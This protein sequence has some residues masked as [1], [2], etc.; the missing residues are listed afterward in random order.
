MEKVRIAC[1]CKLEKER[2]IW[3]SLVIPVIIVLSVL[4]IV[5]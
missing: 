1:Q 5:D 3:P 4:L 2:V